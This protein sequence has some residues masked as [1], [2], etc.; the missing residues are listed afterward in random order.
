MDGGNDELGCQQVVTMLRG[1]E[2]CG[3]CCIASPTEKNEVFDQ[4][5]RV[6]KKCGKFIKLEQRNS[7]DFQ[8]QREPE[9]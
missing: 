7:E 2:S 1:I 8:I 3:G 9:C 6:E 5:E 4:K